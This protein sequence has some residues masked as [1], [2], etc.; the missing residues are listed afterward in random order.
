MKNIILLTPLLL[1]SS[2]GP[3]ATDVKAA[4]EKTVNSLA[5]PQVVG[6]LSDGRTLKRSFVYAAGCYTDTVYFVE[7]QDGGATTTVNA[8]RP[9]GKTT[10]HT[11]EVFVDGKRY[12]ATK[13]E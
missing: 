1:L 13:T 12:S 8:E 4:E 2:C 9:Q 10:L 3:S 7:N 5:K 11:V 6:T